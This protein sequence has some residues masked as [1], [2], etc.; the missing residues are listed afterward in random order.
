MYSTNTHG[1]H[2]APAD[3]VRSGRG[4]SRRIRALL[5]GGLVLGLGTA[6]TLASWND[7]EFASG[8]FASGVFGIEGSSTNGT[9]FS[10]HSTSGTAAAL[11]FTVTP[12]SLA[13]SDIVY[14]PFAVRL[15]ANA[16]NNANIVL[17][18]AGTTGTLTGL[19]Y[20]V[21]Q[22]STW[23]CSAATTGTTIVA[24]GTALTASPTA[25]TI[26]LTKGTTGNPGAP[27]YLCVIVTAGATLV[28][29]STGTATWQLTATS[30]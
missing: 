20:Q 1:A 8:T 4:L 25:S 18:N 27:A 10:D 26:S 15:A 16:T 23:G 22:P 29:G 14:S 17:S 12:T 21:I 30:I 19:T 3:G 24:A 9:T 28:Q 7:S 6:V 13:P 11:T 5:A 2:R